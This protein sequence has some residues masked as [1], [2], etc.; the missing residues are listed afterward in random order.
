MSLRV[1]LQMDALS[2]INPHTD[3][4]LRLGIEAQRRGYEVWQYTPDKLHYK[5]GDVC[6]RASR[7]F[8]HDDETHW[9]ELSEEALHDIR[10]FDVVWLRQDPPFNMAYLTT[11]YLLERVHP[12][13]YVVNHPASVRNLPEK[14]FP[15]ELKQFMTPTL[16]A[17]DIRS[18]REF[19]AEY[20]DI[21]IKPLYGHGGNTIFRLKQDDA[22]FGA[23]MET[24]FATSKDPWMVQKF[25]PE[26]S[27]REV[28]IILIDGTFSAIAGRIPPAGETRAALRVG[29]KYVKA[30][31]TKRHMEICEAL[32]PLLKKHELLL[33]G[34]DVIGDW[35][36][37]INITSPSSIP[38]INRLY[39]TRLES[40]VWDALERHLP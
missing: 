24:L 15:T 23:L 5:N 20:K 3:T 18:I 26:M 22:N 1:A 27:D 33:T 25:L 16:I 13:P 4:T 8:L 34:I 6:V 38:P 31:A 7:A 39:G 40:D 14:W 11:T 19:R 35:L 2:S 28:R 30:E 9:F 12:K 36:T 37:E 10:D 29:A 32:S 17:S 21:I